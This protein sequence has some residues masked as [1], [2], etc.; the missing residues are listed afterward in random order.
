MY[1]FISIAN[2]IYFFC[3]NNSVFRQNPNGTIV[4][5]LDCVV[6][7]VNLSDKPTTCID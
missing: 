6:I 4:W 3:L 1:S 7:N 5:I 2:I